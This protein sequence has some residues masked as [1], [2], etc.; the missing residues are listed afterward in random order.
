[1]SLV[2]LCSAECNPLT[3]TKEMQNS[4]LFNRKIEV[5]GIG[6]KI[7]DSENSKFFRKLIVNF[8]ENAFSVVDIKCYSILDHKK[9]VLH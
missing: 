7:A 9:V 8:I 4:E 5:L 1:M 2:R 3:T 6:K